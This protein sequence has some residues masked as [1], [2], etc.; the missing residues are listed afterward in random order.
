MSDVHVN[1]SAS[2]Q[3]TKVLQSKRRRRRQWLTF[4]RMV[5]YGI[6]NFTRNS[7]LTIAATVVMTVTLVSIFITVAAQSIVQTTVD[8]ISSNVAIGVYLKSGTT[9]D[10]AQPIMDK[11]SRLNSVKAVSFVDSNQALKQVA[12][13]NKGDASTLQ[14]LTEATNELPATISVV[15][16]D[17][18]NTNQFDTFVKT[19]P[20][21]QKYI[22]PS[23]A[24]ASLGTKKGIIQTI[25]Q[26]M[27]VAQKI[28]LVLSI[29]FIAL[30]VLII[31]NTIRMAIFTRKEEI[32]MMKLIGA[33]RQ[34]IRGPFI[35][36]A[37]VYGFIGAVFATGLGYGLLIFTQQKIGNFINIQPTIESVTTYLGVVLLIMIILGALIGMVSSLLATRRYLKI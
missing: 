24:P 13:K 1:K 22:D 23:R 27:L 29:V 14:A 31:F 32:Q 12:D 36:E 16:R 17:L 26:W 6:N 34:F 37:M 20:T 19:D 10:Q 4:M 25:G 11:L 5:R 30:S 7:W 28:A 2:K 15:M 8:A 33:D 9:T 35:V 18:N 3:N 21:L